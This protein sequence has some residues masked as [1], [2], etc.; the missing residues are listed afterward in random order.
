MTDEQLISRAKELQ[1][2]ARRILKELD[3]LEVISAISEPE[4]VGSAKNG[5]ILTL[6][7][8]IH[9]WMEKADLT[10]VANLL[11]ALVKMP[12]IQ[13]VQFNNYLDI[14]RDYRADRIDFPHAYYVGLRTMQPSGEWKIDMWFGERGNIGNYDESEIDG[15]TDEQHLAILRLK[16]KW[17]DGKGYKDGVISVDFYRSVMWHN[18]NDEKGFLEYL[19]TIKK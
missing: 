19:Q 10:T 2:E 17:N 4:V 9:A 12:T 18:V 13:K 14:R 6:D 16:E 5:L 7:I 8:D 1:T 11:P 15:V 3:L